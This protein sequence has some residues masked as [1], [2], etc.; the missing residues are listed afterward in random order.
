M[1]FIPDQTLL[2]KAKIL[3]SGKFTYGPFVPHPKGRGRMFTVICPEHGEFLQSVSAHLSGKGCKSCAATALQSKNRLTMEDVVNKVKKFGRNYTYVSLDYTDP[4]APILT[5]MCNLHGTKVQNV[6]NHLA[7]KGCNQCR[8]G[9][10]AAL[11]TKGATR[12]NQGLSDSA[13]AD[14][15]KAMTDGYI[16]ARIERRNK[17]AQIVSF[18][19]S[20]GE[21]THPAYER[22][23]NG[24]GCPSCSAATRGE[25]S[26][27]DMEQLTLKGK[28]VHGDKYN[29]LDHERRGETLWLHIACPTHGAFWQVAGGHFGGYGCPKCGNDTV[30]ES[31]SKHFNKWVEEA[32]VKHG[33]LYTYKSLIK[34]RSEPA[35]LVI[36]CSKHGDFIQIAKDHLRGAGCPKCTSR[37]SKQNIEVAQFLTDNNVEHYLEYKIPDSK[38]TMDLYIPE[39]R[40]GIEMNGI[41]WHSDEYRDKNYHAKK[42]E[43][44]EA[45]GIRIV[46]IFDDEWKDK[47]AIVE[48]VIKHTLGISEEVKIAA[49][50]C[51][52]SA[53]PA[54]EARNFMNKYH[55]QGFVGATMYY[56]LFH[57]GVLVASAGFSMKER[58]RSGRKSTEQAELVRYSTSVNVRGG[59]GKLL[60]YAQTS[61]GFTKLTTFSD[62]RLFSGKL[63]EALGF[64]REAEIPPDYFYCRD[65]KRVHKSLLQKSRVRRAAEKGRELYY[66][67][68]T[69]RELSKLNGYSKVWDCGKIRWVRKW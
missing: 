35:K 6:H 43:E 41:Y 26:R 10:N 14:K 40:L 31:T 29:Y 7:G 23:T 51:S 59:L 67:D 60:N 66:P 64:T 22:L 8:S 20:H 57:Q 38:L 45:A 3:H 11:K 4:K 16:F 37:V 61:L 24:R 5:Y 30:S 63:Y 9:V 42:Q 28:E 48:R 68:M 49:R 21:F 53:I 47:R 69:E 56:G 65:G 62:I 54:S 36:E 2:Q 19:S 13:F 32:K 46:H 58:G 39:K 25:N 17:R 34:T 50:H 27:R 15:A 52:V 1:P 33:A 55:I 18:C 12:P 44:A